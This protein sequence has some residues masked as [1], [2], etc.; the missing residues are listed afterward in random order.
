VS[1]PKIIYLGPACEA[2]TGDGRTWAEDNPWPDCE[3][4]HRPVQYVL[5]ETFDRMKAER[6]ALHERLT[7]TDQRLDELISAVR[8][9]NH[10]K[11]HEVFVPGDDEPQFQQRKEWVDWLLG[12]CDAASGQVAPVPTESALIAAG[13]GYPLSKEDAVR[14]YQAKLGPI[15]DHPI[16]ENCEGCHGCGHDYYGDP[17]QHCIRP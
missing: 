7:S 16:N 8:S 15:T 9:I 4:G 2:D 11:H 5:G 12:L 3:C 1:E 17:C 6:D 10:A 13:L 14:A